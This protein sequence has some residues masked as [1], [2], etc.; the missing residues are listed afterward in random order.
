MKLAGA[1]A[2]ARSLFVMRRV[3]IRV[4]RAAARFRWS[5]ATSG[6]TDLHFFGHIFIGPPISGLR[7]IFLMAQ[8]PLLT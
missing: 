6:R 5:L 7:S 8:P 1:F 4:R 3:G 2:P